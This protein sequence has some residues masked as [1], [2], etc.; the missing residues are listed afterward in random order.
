LSE[1]T[2]NEVRP[3]LN[4]DAVNDPG[5]VLYHLRDGQAPAQA[6]TRVQSKYVADILGVVK[7]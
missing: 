6:A 3:G 4:R 5:P 1:G 7:Y 2:Q